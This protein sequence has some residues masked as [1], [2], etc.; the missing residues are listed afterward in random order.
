MDSNSGGYDIE[1]VNDEHDITCVICLDVLC[2]PMQAVKCG[3]RFCKKCMFGLHRVY[4]ET[5]ERRER[6]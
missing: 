6:Y 2:Q 3:H 4:S 1:F 5:L